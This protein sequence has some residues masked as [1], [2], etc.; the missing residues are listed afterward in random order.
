[1][2]GRRIKVMVVVD[3]NEDETPELFEHCRT[4]GGPEGVDIR[5]LASVV[6]G[7]KAHAHVKGVDHFYER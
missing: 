6:F 4:A 7:R 1:M 3:I 2:A 5:W